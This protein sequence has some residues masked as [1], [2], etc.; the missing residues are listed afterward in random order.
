MKASA[1]LCSGRCAFVRIDAP[2]RGFQDAGHSGGE[3]RRRDFLHVPA[4]PIAL[5]QLARAQSYP[6][7]AIRYIVPVPAGGGNDMI[8]RVVTQRWG[9][10]LGQPFLVDNQSGGGGVVACQAT[11][12]AAPDGST[13][14][15]GFVATHGTTPATRHVNY[16][17]VKDFTAVGMIGASPNVLVIHGSVPARTVAEFVDYVKRNPGRLNYAS[18]GNGSLTH[19]TM[20]LF[21]Q[22]TG[23]Y[24]LHI[25]YRGVAPALTDLLAG[26][27]QAMF[28][29]LASALPH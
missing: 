17:A 13:L 5:P 29:S 11:M 23:A 2:R 18:A 24:M 25:P 16:D 4:A 1:P 12:R 7:R 10:L 9:V 21:K 8:A 27:T 14:M 26:R 15:Q 28:P 20:E 6:V 19:L 3:M 22:D